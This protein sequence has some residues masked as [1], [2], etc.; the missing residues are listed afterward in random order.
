MARVKI[1]MEKVNEFTKKGKFESIPDLQRENSKQSYIGVG[2]LYRPTKSKKRGSGLPKEFRDYLTRIIK[3]EKQGFQFSS[4][5]IQDVLRLSRIYRGK[6]LTEEAKQTLKTL[7]TKQIKSQAV[8]KVEPPLQKT[9]KS[10]PRDEYQPRPEL[11][12]QGQ[13]QPTFYIPPD[14][15]P[16]EEEI[17]KSQVENYMSTMTN[18]DLV[19]IYRLIL[20]YYTMDEIREMIKNGQLPMWMAPSDAILELKT[21]IN[22]FPYHIQHKIQILYNYM[23][24][25]LL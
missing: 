14:E 8:K 23:D 21:Q 18:P 1:D 6:T 17:I 19:E 2:Q 16:T 12:V 25:Q 7:N 4:K 9:I 22:I 10:T 15:L 11:Q 24:L 5:Y 3:L 13:A 20:D